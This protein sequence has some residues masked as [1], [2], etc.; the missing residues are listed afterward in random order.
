MGSNVPPK[1]PRP[2]DGRRSPLVPRLR[3]PLELGGTD[4]DQ[5]ARHDARAAQPGVDPEPGEVALEALRRLLD[6]EVGLGRDALDA[7]AA[8]AEDAV[9]LA[10]RS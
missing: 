7:R 5:V 8:D 4:A 2:R 1:T 3:L 6:V 10:A 9:L